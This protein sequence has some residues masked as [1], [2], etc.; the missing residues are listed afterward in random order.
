MLLYPTILCRIVGHFVKFFIIDEDSPQDDV[1]L[2]DASA[3]EMIKYHI[4]GLAVVN[5]VLRILDEWL[6]VAVACWHDGMDETQQAIIRVYSRNRHQLVSQIIEHVLDSF[7]GV[8]ALDQVHY[9]EVKHPFHVA[10]TA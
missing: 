7:I 8:S 10:Q 5:E 3:K 6:V 9:I 4:Q 2:S 1:F